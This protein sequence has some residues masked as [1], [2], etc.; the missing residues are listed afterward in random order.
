MYLH[1]HCIFIFHYFNLF[2]QI[3]LLACLAQEI[4]GLNLANKWTA[5]HTGWKK[6][7]H[8]IEASCSNFK[9]ICG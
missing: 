8:E 3:I 1:T 2:S 7:H 4:I 6:K 5:T 9:L